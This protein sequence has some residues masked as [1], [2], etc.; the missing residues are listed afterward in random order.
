[1]FLESPNVQHVNTTL[2]LG[3]GSNINQPLAEGASAAVTIYALSVLNI[4]F[5]KHWL[6]MPHAIKSWVTFILI[7][8]AFFVF[9]RSLLTPLTV[10]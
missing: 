7:D 1:M 2:R 4:S 5:A 8:C 6:E 3:D 9:G 10:Y